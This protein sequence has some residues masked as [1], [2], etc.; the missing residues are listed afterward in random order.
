MIKIFRKRNYFDTTIWSFGIHHKNQQCI[1]EYIEANRPNGLNP[2]EIPIF[3]YFPYFSRRTHKFL[4]ENK[5]T[6]R[7]VQFKE[8]YKNFVINSVLSGQFSSFEKTTFAYYLLLQDRIDECASVFK[9]L[10]AEERK[11]H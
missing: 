11:S 9:S 6:I 2:V 1:V 8:T 4:D 5:S 3:E 10:T 7:N